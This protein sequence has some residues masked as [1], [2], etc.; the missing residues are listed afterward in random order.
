MWKRSFGVPGKDKE[1]ARQRALELFP[2]AH[3]L[4]ARKR[5]HG[6]AEAALMLSS[7]SRIPV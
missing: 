6:R 3:G 5:G 7:A 1:A 4:F 2:A